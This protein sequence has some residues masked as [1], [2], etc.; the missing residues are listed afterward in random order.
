MLGEVAL[1]AG[2]FV[3]FAAILPAVGYYAWLLLY[4]MW[5]RR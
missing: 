5:S 2:T 1:E 4:K 3:L